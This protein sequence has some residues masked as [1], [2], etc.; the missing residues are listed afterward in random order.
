[1]Q[2]TLNKLRKVNTLDTTRSR[3]VAAGIVISAIVLVAAIV[4]V[5]TTINARNKPLDE[6]TGGK[7]KQ[8]AIIFSSPLAEYQ[9]ILKDYVSTG[10]RLNQTMNWWET[11]K[12][13]DIEA[14]LGTP[15]LAT[16][17]GTVQK[18]YFHPTEGQQIT[19][20]HRDGLETVYSNLAR[21]VLVTEGQAVTKGQEIATVGQTQ[22][23]EFSKTPHLRIEVYKDGVRIDPN[24]YIDFSDK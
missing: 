7:E 16:F 10:F 18:V 20:R 1:M 2:T 8:T 3:S 5:S 19:L 6:F 21:E 15:V 13:I 14:P 23:S 12:C 9:S 11:H 17:A 24:T 4:I 22:K